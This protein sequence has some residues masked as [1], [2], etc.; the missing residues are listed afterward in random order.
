MEL[1]SYNVRLV[2]GLG[3]WDVAA[4]EHVNCSG[5][6]RMLIIELLCLN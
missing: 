5:I 2:D 6:D 3:A 4:S 1:Q